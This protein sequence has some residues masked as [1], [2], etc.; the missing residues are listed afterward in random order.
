M[1]G[2]STKALGAGSRA[3]RAPGRSQ[4]GRS[5]A[6]AK[7]VQWAGQG[8]G[9]HALRQLASRADRPWVG[10]GNKGRGGKAHH[11]W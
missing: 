9:W 2:C 8:R 7:L 10:E 1:G 3:G 5:G 4:E 11:R 6:G